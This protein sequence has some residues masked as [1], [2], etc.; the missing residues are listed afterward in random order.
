MGDSLTDTAHWSNRERQLARAP[1][2]RRKRKIRRQCVRHQPGHRRHGTAPQS[3]LAA[4][5]DAQNARPDL[6][7]IFFGYNDASA[8]MTPPPSGPHKPTPWSAFAGPR[9]VDPTC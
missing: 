7:T 6:V 3:G 9:A 1:A 8:G 5:L 2:S 4:A